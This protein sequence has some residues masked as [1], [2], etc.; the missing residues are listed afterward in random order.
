MS[1]FGNLLAPITLAPR[2]LMWVFKKVQEEADLE[3]NDPV[4]LRT[5]LMALQRRVAAAEITEAQYEAQEER[6]LARLDNI[7]LRQ[8]ADRAAATDRS[9]GTDRAA[10][11]GSAGRPMRGRRHRRRGN[12]ARR[13]MP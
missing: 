4:R 10:A 5:E 8:E 6:I 3:L 1:L 12:R 13:G 11:G 2:G 9:A 7:E